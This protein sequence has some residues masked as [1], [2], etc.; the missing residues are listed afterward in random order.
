MSKPIAPDE[1]DAAA[2]HSRNL[3]RVTRRVE[4]ATNAR[5]RAIVDAVVGGLSLRQVAAAVKLSHSQVALIV[6]R[7]PAADLRRG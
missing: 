6:R 3:A 1:L 7:Q 5:D 2:R 4:E